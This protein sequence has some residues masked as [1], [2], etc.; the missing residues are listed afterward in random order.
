MPLLTPP[1]GGQRIV[2]TSASPDEAA[3]FVN[4]G[5]ISFSY[6]FWSG[7]F[8]GAKVYDAFVSAKN[9]M[10]VHGYQTAMV[11]ANGNGTGNEKEDKQ[12]ADDYMIGNG[13]AT[14]ADI[15]VIGLIVDDQTLSKET[16]AEIWVESIITTGTIS[17]VWAVIVPPE[18]ESEDT[19]NPVTELPTVELKNDGSG[20][21]EGTYSSFTTTGTYTVAVYAMDENN[22]VSLPVETTVEQ[23][24]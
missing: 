11:D 22:A 18:Q 17:R 15:P 9:A 24:K 23:T 4:Q 10:E 13:I 5:V 6:Y 3:F 2:I 14:A 20:R 7:I 8:S 19:D 21:Y 12:L 16:S 1:S